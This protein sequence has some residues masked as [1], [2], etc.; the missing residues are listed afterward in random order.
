MKNSISIR[1][2][3]G[4]FTGDKVADCKILRALTGRHSF[5]ESEYDQKLILLSDMGYDLNVLRPTAKLEP[6]ADRV[7]VCRF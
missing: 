4:K 6:L 2:L 3:R 1:L 7:N 5:P